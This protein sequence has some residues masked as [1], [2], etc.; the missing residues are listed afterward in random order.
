MTLSMDD[1]MIH[2]VN[3]N[4]IE[5]INK[6]TNAK[7]NNSWQPKHNYRLYGI[8]CHSGSMGGGHYIS[9]VSYDY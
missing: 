4:N 6:F 9:Y 1:Y 5:E 8:V 7:D 2:A 3:N